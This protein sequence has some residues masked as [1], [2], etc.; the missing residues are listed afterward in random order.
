[1][2]RG[3]KLVV[4]WLCILSMFLGFLPGNLFLNSTYAAANDLI[5]PNP[6]AVNLTKKADPAGQ[7]QWDITLTVEGKN[8]KTTSDVVLVIDRSGSMDQSKRMTNAKTAANKFVDNLLIKDST[9][10]I[11]VVTF[12]KTASEKSSFAGYGQKD[13]LKK[14]IDAIT[15]SNEGTNIQ[16]GLNK[17][18]GMLAGSQAQNKVIVLLSDGAPTYSYKASHAAAYNWPEKKYNFTLYDFN[19]NGK[20]LGS[21]SS[22]DLGWTQAYTVDGKKVEDNGIAALSEAKL[23]WD[24][25]IGIYSIGLEVGNDPDAKYVL[26]NVQNKGYYSSNSADLGKVFSELSGQ[27]AYAAQ[28]AIVTDPMG[29]MFDLVGKPTV[30]QGTIT[31]DDKT[32]TFKWDAGNI[33]E[34]S[35]ATLTYRVK[36]DQSKHPDPNALY[37]TNGTTTIDYTDIHGNNVKK[38]FAVP[39]VSYGKGSI[40]V[41]GYRVNADGQPVN[42]EGAVVERPELAQQ[43]Y[44]GAFAQDGKEALDIGNT[45]SVDAP[46]IEGY[47]LEA[48]DNPTSVKLTMKEPT[49]TVWFGFMEAVAQHVTV[50]YLDKETNKAL[51]EPT[52]VTGL[53]G[54]QIELEAKKVL[55]YT[56]EKASDKY[57][58]TGKE[59][60]EYTFYYTADKQTV[61]VKYL[62][63][64][65]DKELKAPATEEGATD[66]T[67]TIVAPA[68]PGYA[69]EQPSRTYK[70]TAEKNQEVV[71][72]Y[73][74]T[75]QQVT[76]QHLVE[77]TNNELVQPT[78]KG[79]P[80]GEEVNVAL[81]I[82]GYTP[83]KGTETYTFNGDEKQSHTVYYTPDKQTVTIRYVDQDTNQEISE[84]TKQEGVTDQSITIEAP[85]ITGYTPVDPEVEYKFTADEKQVVTIYYKAIE[86][87]VTVKHLVQGTEKELA[88]PTT[89]KGHQGEKVN[90]A[91]EIEGY[92]P[93]E[94]TETYTFTADKDQSH[95]VYYTADKQ[96]VTIRY[97]DQDTNKDIKDATTQEGVTDQEITLTSPSITGYTPVKPEVAYKF[98]ADEKQEVVIYYTADKPAPEMRTITVKYLEEGTN[99]Q[100]QEPATLQGEVGKEVLLKAPNIEGYVT[101]KPEVSYPVSSQNN[102]EYVFYYKKQVSE[103]EERTVSIHHV[104]QETN[105]RIAETTTLTG[106]VG[107]TLRWSEEPITVVDAVYS[108]L[109]I[110]HEYLITDAPEQE[111]TVYYKKGQDETIVQLLVRFL[112]K[113]TNEELG[114]KTYSGKPDEAITIK[115]D[116]ITV[117]GAVYKPEQAEYPYRFT[118]EALQ[119]LIVYFIPDTAPVEK[120][121]AVTV[122]YLEQGTGAELAASTVLKGKAGSTVTLTAV[123]VSGYTPVQ[124]SVVYQFEDKD[125]QEFVF[126]YTKNSPVTPPV[127]PSPSNPGSS[128]GNSGSV[129]P[130]PPAPPVVPPLPPAP[131]KLDTANHFNYINGYP[132]GMV[133][134]ENNI[135]REEVAAIFYRLMDDATRSDYMK[136]TSSYKDVAA[137]RWSSKNIATMENAGII[138][139][140]PDGTFKPGRSITRAEFAAIASRFD[141]LDQQENATFSDIKGHWAEKYIVSAANKGWIKGYPDGTFKPDQYIT[142][143]EAMAFI[144]SVLNR[145]VKAEGIHKAAK[146]WPDNTPNKWYYA[147]VLEAT[148]NHDYSRN[149]DGAET[150]EQVKP[151]RV[152]P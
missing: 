53:K 124:S 126:Y 104:D 101:E 103:P 36:M 111:Y 28:K 100:L 133:K 3:L 43:L 75:E 96:T 8:I 34:G 116:P 130:L 83:V 70:F 91:K 27:I 47:Q 98:T 50:K 33:I 145:K 35:P 5:W 135:S 68:I 7:G 82:P 88:D 37:P 14:V 142:R 141:D 95:T 2:K 132:D 113:L 115:P 76:V 59:G 131:P 92:T 105:D 110:N 125:G 146:A 24:G 39:Q 58:F 54:K 152:Y 107:E 144:N 86:Q 87:Q 57:T 26:N 61:T 84:P 140:Y 60:Q 17:A 52:D 45:Y 147:D 40:T 42:A 93:V 64:G 12:D 62:E 66:K 81:E 11:A 120:D 121:Q 114:Q 71:L 139:G 102:Q 32:E 44:S 109:E 148:N 149:A 77:G 1:M 122:K 9:T 119:E 74:A 21:G 136:S 38:N 134:P 49:P 85:A 151:D 97:V 55:G 78:I 65:T 15:V 19:Y 118:G 108:P 56:P 128:S 129:T 6:G 69:P 106:K 137:T 25:G 41:K 99:R 10:R 46:T 112:N 117:S 138:T 31:W 127:D 150:W 80:T 94:G 89:H 13:S 63:R 4:S 20:V 51:A 16:A 72:H 73:N 123:P 48:G 23:A 90:V 29:D 79:G 22:Y 18:R 30:S 143:A 67:I